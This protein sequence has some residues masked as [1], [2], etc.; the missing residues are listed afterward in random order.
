[1]SCKCCLSSIHRFCS[2]VILCT[3][4]FIVRGSHVKFSRCHGGW[5]ALYSSHIF[6]RINTPN[7]LEA[8]L[9]GTAFDGQYFKWYFVLVYWK[10]LGNVCGEGEC[11][12]IILETS[13]FLLCDLSQLGVSCPRPRWHKFYP[14]LR[15][16]GMTTVPSCVN[17]V[18]PAADLVHNFSHPR[19][20]ICAS[21]SKARLGFTKLG[22]GHSRSQL[23]STI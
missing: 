12:R 17:L 11:R 13:S 19:P 18:V 21:H 14:D 7:S 6:G 1:M 2:W 9:F 16:A 10:L 20:M 22:R 4:R 8:H 23:N 3:N 15:A 5:L